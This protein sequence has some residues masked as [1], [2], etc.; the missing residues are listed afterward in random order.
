MAKRYLVL[1]TQHFTLCTLA[2]IWP[3]ALIANRI[4]PTVLG[5]PFLF[6]WYVLWMLILFVGMWLAYLK[7]HGGD[8][9]D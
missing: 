4:E 1:L 7:Q 3:G 8:R 5:L 2:M 9:H 6:F